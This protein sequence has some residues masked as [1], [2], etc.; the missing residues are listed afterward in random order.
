[1]I[2]ITNKQEKIFRQMSEDEQRALREHYYS[3]GVIEMP[4]YDGGYT[5]IS[6]PNFNGHIVYRA[7][8]QPKPKLRPWGALEAIGKVVSKKGSDTFSVI[9]VCNTMRALIADGSYSFDQLLE[10]W[11]HVREDG[12]IGPCGEEVK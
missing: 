10:D 12:T 6:D 5:S 11:E 9:T 7:V 8:L 1:M 3:G 4:D 2:D